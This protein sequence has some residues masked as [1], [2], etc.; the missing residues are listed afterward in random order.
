MNAVSQQQLLA[1]IQTL[2]GFGTRNTFSETQR[3]DYGIGAARRWIH[4]EFL[5]VNGGALQ[6]GFDDFQANIGGLTTNQRNVVATL[7][8][9][10]DHPGVI[11]IAAHYDSRG[12]DPDSGGGLAPGANDNASGTAI[13][14]EL[15]RLL[16]SRSWRQTIVFVA[17]AAEEQGT[18]GSRH[19]VQN[20]IL[21]GR[22]FDAVLTNDIVG[23]RPGIPQSIRI[24]TPGPDLSAARQLARYIE[25][26]GG[27]YLPAF[28]I[29]SINAL[30]RY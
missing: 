5:R 16:S 24:F 19:Y 25:L 2:E 7:P 28:R 27:L 17:F 23:G 1:Y 6:V 15:A 8:G 18:F 4:D 22:V 12:A 20:R 26:V 10:G 30:D 9:I 3:D 21:D 29:D 11:V 13:L 14:L